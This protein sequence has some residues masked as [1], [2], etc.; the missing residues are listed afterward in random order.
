MDFEALGH[1]DSSAGGKEVLETFDNPGVVQVLMETDEVTAICPVTGQPDWYTVAVR[2]QPRQ[3]CLES[4][5]LKLYLWGFRGHGAFGEKLATTIVDDLYR[6]LEPAEIV[7]EVIQKPRG[8]ISI[9]STA[10]LSR[11]GAS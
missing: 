5:S 1:K 6:I 3:L 8:G 11:P 7:V 4:K 2:Y 9:T 10:A